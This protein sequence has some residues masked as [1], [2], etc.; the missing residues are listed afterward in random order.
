MKKLTLLLV[1]TFFVA[2]SVIAQNCPPSHPYEA[3]ERCW[4]D[5]AQ[6]ESGG[7]FES[8]DPTNPPNAPSNLVSTTQSIN[9]ISIQ[10]TDN[11]DDK[12]SF[13]LYRND[14]YY[15]SLGGDVSA[16]TDV[17]LQSNTLYS[18]YVLAKNGALIS[19]ASNTISVSTL[20][21]VPNS[22]LGTLSFTSN[23]IN[24]GWEIVW[25]NVEN[26]L[27]YSL[28]IIISDGSNI[29]SDIDVEPS[30]FIYT[31]SNPIED[32]TYSYQ[33]TV[34]NETTT[35]KS[36]SI[37][38]I[39]SSCANSNLEQGKVTG[40]FTPKNGKILMFLGQ[41]NNS[42]DEYVNSGQFPEI[43]GFTNYT[44]IYDFDGLENTSNYGSGD[45]CIQCGLDKYPNAAVA[46]GLY[47]VE[48]NDG[49]GEDHPNGLT[50]IVNGLYDASIDRFANFAK[51]NSSTA[52]F[53]RIGYEFDG[54]WNHYD[55]TKYINAYRYLVD[56][57][58]EQGVENVAYVWQSAAYGFT[59]NGNPIDAWYPG[60]AYVDYIGLSFFFYDENFNG[61]N[62]Q[63]LLDMAR[64]KQKP[65]IMAEVSAQ[66][67]DIE[68]G[69][70]ANYA[71]PA[72]KTAMTGEV[73]WQQY[74]ED[75]LIP[76]IEGNEDVIRAI[77]YINADWQSQEQWKWPDAGNGYWG[78]TRVQSNA[79]VSAQWNSFLN[80]GKIQNGANN[81]YQILTEGSCDDDTTIVD[82]PV[83]IVLPGIAANIVVNAVSSSSAIVTWDAATDAESYVIEYGTNSGVF[84]ASKTTSATQITLN[85]LLPETVY[86]VNVYA[87]NANGNGALGAEA[88]AVTESLPE[89]GSK[90][91]GKFTPKNGK[92]LL[93]IGQDL[94]SMAGYREGGMPEPGAV[95]AYVSF[96]M[97]TQDNYGINYGATGLDNSGN[98]TGVDTDWGAGPLNASSSALGWEQSALILAMSIT[99]NWNQNGLQGIAN[100][101]FEQHIDKLALFCNTFPDKNI[102]L[103]IG[104]EFD[105]RWNA[106][107]TAGGLYPAGHHKKDEYIAAW[108]HIVDGLDNRGVSN[109]AFV[110]QSSTSP[111]DDVLDGYFSYGGNLLAAREDIS[112]WY[113][114]DEYVDWCG[115]SWFIS[116]TEASNYFGFDD[117]Q[118][119]PNQDDLTD[120]ML[121]FARL[122]NKPVMIAE[123]APQGYDLEISEYDTTPSL[124]SRASTGYTYEGA[125]TLFTQGLNAAETQFKPGTWFAN[126]SAIEAWNRWY[127]PFLNYIHDNEDVIRAVTYINANW[128]TQAKWSDPYNEGYWGD[129]RIE[130]NPEIK[131]LWLGETNTDF[132]LLGDTNIP[133]HL[134]EEASN[135]RSLTLEEEL[136]I[137]E[138]VVYPNPVKNKIKIKGVDEIK[139]LHLYSSQGKLIKTSKENLMEVEN[140]SPGLY[141]LKI[142]KTHIKKLIIE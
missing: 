132:W 72:E 114:G 95:V 49:V 135:S 138:V 107:E 94:A 136:K 118:N 44:N 69:T 31:E 63:F 20:E 40:K 5:K 17:N 126:L 58:N 91:E 9:T 87:V 102:F 137:L 65:I 93:A 4:E 10:W 124:V 57:L 46:I 133:S 115:I 56:R 117:V 47:M 88:S 51:G 13:E 28:N 67:Y 142:N 101:Q 68:E 54:Q 32:H 53:L 105:G 16:F 92:T 77:S 120:E 8:P 6:A 60:D 128:N 2:L 45:M 84:T 22:D 131:T 61:P 21:D 48:D 103:R 111:V 64:S 33:L 74:F 73:I 50:D 29:L 18:Y 121:A 99:E 24:N 86:Y 38:K 26:A 112:E 52:F 125:K 14:V 80:A 85:G 108:R 123:S 119:L 78:D 71:N 100:G 37:Q 25:N 90:I 39:R 55:P 15:I 98:F 97:L 76:F 122:H 113:P 70:F 83:E 89:T 23:A 96:Y 81:L 110:W 109:V 79:Y 75:Q 66:Y 11:S 27:A 19:T 104:Y 42:V 130:A 127:T 59:Y 139:E 43:G 36:N 62:L 129:T 1:A 116:P 141:L 30:G 41:D 12:Q 34:S 7:C 106:E 140:L 134:Y 3:C 35:K 82:P